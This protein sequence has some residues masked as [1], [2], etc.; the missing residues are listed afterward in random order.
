VLAR[1]VHL[2]MCQNSHRV[3]I[4]YRPSFPPVSRRSTTTTATD[5]ATAQLQIQRCI[6]DPHLL[7]GVGPVPTQ[8]GIIC[9]ER[10]RSKGTQSWQDRRGYAWLSVSRRWKRLILLE[11]SVE[12]NRLVSLSWLHLFALFTPNMSAHGHNGHSQ[13]QDQ[14]QDQDQTSQPRSNR[15]LQIQ[16][17]ERRPLLRRYLSHEH[18]AEPVFS[19]MPNPH[20]HL[21]V[22]TNIHRIRRDVV[23]I[24]EDYMSLEQ[25]RDVRINISVIRPLVDKLYDLDDTSI[26]EPAQVAA[27]FFLRPPR[28]LSRLMCSSL[29]PP[30]EPHPVPARAVSSA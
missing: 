5:A 4:P 12:Q 6:K 14:D 30:C 25:L 13:N 18:D 20:S 9:Q 19:C 2:R 15:H 26:G 27:R 29:L 8:R 7:N 28:S 21:P 11:R 10:R 17:P 1:R 23:S 3:R 16:E 22:Y 24:V